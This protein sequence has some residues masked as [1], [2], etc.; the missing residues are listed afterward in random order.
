MQKNENVN[1]IFFYEINVPS[2]CVNHVNIIFNAI[3]NVF[4]YHLLLLH[5]IMKS[6]VPEGQF[7]LEL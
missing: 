7:L 5:E 3:R 2:S 1:E 4:I 6:E